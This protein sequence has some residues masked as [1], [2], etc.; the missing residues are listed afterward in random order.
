MEGIDWPV[1]DSRLTVHDVTATC[2]LSGSLSR[3]GYKVTGLMLPRLPATEFGC[4]STGHALAILKEASIGQERVLVSRVNSSIFFLGLS[5]GKW[6]V[7][8]SVRNL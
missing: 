7:R 8:R 5:L 3:G 1:V 4:F 2:C 6:T